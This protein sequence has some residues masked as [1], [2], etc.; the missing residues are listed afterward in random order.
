MCPS[1]LQL[2]ENQSLDSNKLTGFY[3]RPKT[4]N[5]L[6]L[7]WTFAQNGLNLKKKK[8][9][10]QSLCP[11]SICVTPKCLTAWVIEFECLDFQLAHIF[12]NQWSAK[13]W[14]GGQKNKVLCIFHFIF[15][16]NE[17]IHIFIKFYTTIRSES[18]F[19]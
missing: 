19:S 6:N 5:S 1:I 7:R 4:Q 15:L 17:S 8:T 10:W 11:V 2:T 14:N 9:E 18:L 13:F 12:L 3:M 16:S